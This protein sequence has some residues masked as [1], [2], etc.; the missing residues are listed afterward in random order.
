MR[1]GILQDDEAV[2]PILGAILLLAI[3]ITILT[4]V[5]LTFVP[6]WNSQ[7]DMSQLAKMSDDFRGLKSAI[8]QSAVSGTTLSSPLTMGFK[9]SPKFLVYNPK[10]TAWTTLSIQKDVWAEVRYNEVLPDGMDDATSIKNVS[11]STITYALH[12]TSNLSSF[13]YEHG[14]IRRGGS[15]YTNSAQTLVANGTIYLLGVNA[16]E[17]ENIRDIGS[18]VMNIYSTSAAKNSVVGKNVWLTLHTRYTDWW[19]DPNNPS[20]LQNQG[21]AIKKIDTANGIVIAYFDSIVIRMGE[22]QVTTMPKKPP[23]HSPP[24][25]LFRV[26]PQN[27]NLPVNGITSLEV[28]VQDFYNN[29]VPNKQV[30]FSVNSTRA[31]TNAYSTAALLQNSAVTGPDGRANIQLKTTGSGLYYIDSSISDPAYSTTFSYPASSQYGFISLAYTGTGPSYAITATLKNRTGQLDVGQTIS[32]STSEGNVSPTSNTTNGSGI[33]RMTL[34]TSTAT[35]LEI[36]DIDIAG[37]TNLSAIIT[38]DTNDTVTVAANRTP[39]GYIFNSLDI[40]AAVSSNGCVSYGKVAGIYTRVICDAQNSSHNVSLGSLTPY[41]AYY[42]IIN[43]SRPGNASVNSSEYMFVT[44]GPAK[45][46]PPASITNLAHDTT[47]PLS[48]NWT[49]TNPSDADFDHVQVYIDGVFVSNSPAQSFNANYFRP[50]ST[51]TIGTRTVDVWDNMNATWVYDSA[52][53]PSVFTYVFGFLSTSGTVTNLSDAQNGSDGGA[54]AL[55]SE[56]ESDNYTY[57]TSNTTTSGNITNWT[58]MK[59]GSDSGAFANLTEAVVNTS[60]KNNWTDFSTNNG[61]WIFS[62]RILT[63]CTCTNTVSAGNTSSD[64]ISVP[65]SSLFV[66]LSINQG[67]KRHVVE[68]SWRS[69]AIS[70]TNGTPSSASLNFSLRNLSWQ[71]NAWI[72]WGKRRPILINN[73]GNATILTNYQVRLNITYVSGMDTDFSDIRVVNVTSG[74]EVPLYYNITNNANSS[75]GQCINSTYC[76]IYFTAGSIPASVWTNSTYYLYYNNSLANSASNGTNTFVLFDDFDDGNYNGWNVTNGTWDAS[77]KYLNNSVT[78]NSRIYRNFSPAISDFAFEFEFYVE[79]GGL[80][81]PDIGISTPNLGYVVHISTVPEYDLRYMNTSNRSNG[82]AN[83]YVIRPTP[84]TPGLDAYWKTS[85]VTKS[86]TRFNLFLN[87]SLVNATGG[88]STYATS[89]SQFLFMGMSTSA[90]TRKIRYDNII[91]RKFVSPEPAAQLGAE[92]SQQG[93]MANGTF[94]VTLIKPDNTTVF[95]YPTTG[96]SVNSSNWLNYSNLSI[97]TSDFSQ[98]GNYTILLNATL[99]VTSESGGGSCNCGWMEERWDNPVITLNYTNYS[100]NITTNT[101]SVPVGSNYILEINYSND[102]NGGYSVYVFNGTAWNNRG[103][104]NSSTWAIFS[105]TLDSKEN[106]SGNVMVRYGDQNSTG[107]G[108]LSIDYQRIHGVTPVYDL[109]ITTNTTGIPYSTTPQVLQLRYNVSNDNFTL[110]IWNGTTWNNKTTLSSN[111]LSNF[112]ITLQAGELLQDTATTDGS[113]SDIN[114]YYVLVRYLDVN[115][116]STQLA[117][118]YL[119]Y[120]R[121]YSN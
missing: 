72:S 3:G 8:E 112:N 71:P 68:T 14:L 61:S 87:G 90:N 57:V 66:N 79:P 101:S 84:T 89:F 100:L 94:N 95:I 30:S 99:N 2:S 29:P 102:T 107:R 108:N 98:S 75:S 32:F 59:N 104:L 110:Q 52:T 69:P 23:A 105:Y 93:G 92:E 121:V 40:P 39:G 58:N 26:T 38:W 21:G 35:G 17:P 116:S 42:F 13:I 119:D 109:N 33:A 113:V 62:Y 36:T 22:T 37:V 74:L 51:H 97:S 47:T 15:N 91:V 114:R 56:P 106:N 5:Q 81:D 27:V 1:Y 54:S 28:E 7:E 12:G 41:T 11:T 80:L 70:L 67:N 25:R 43:S 9:Y 45:T 16:T 85:K 83:Q 117:T 76:N 82:D 20:S 63:D 96:I 118:L 4:N 88:T 6:V 31:P 103:S 10:E 53:T 24:V 120:Q 86:G 111:S 19:T 46:V 50:N 55:F 44:E 77:N 18:R 64:G 65:L 60:Q 34:N 78:Y 49:W 73:T 115:A 48:I